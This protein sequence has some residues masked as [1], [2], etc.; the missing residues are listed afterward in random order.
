MTQIEEYWINKVW[1]YTNEEIT[2]RV[3]YLTLKQIYITSEFQIQYNFNPTLEE[4]L[5]IKALNTIYDY[6][7]FYNRIINTLT[8]Y[9]DTKSYQEQLDQN[10]YLNFKMKCFLSDLKEEKNRDFYRKQI[11]VIRESWHLKLEDDHIL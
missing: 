1:S 8:N 9:I 4:I 3:F 11:Q 10:P 6:F 7:H 5:E 2:H